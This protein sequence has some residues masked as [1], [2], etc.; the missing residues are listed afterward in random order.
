CREG[1]LL[2]DLPADQVRLDHAFDV[3]WVE[4]FVPSAFRINQAD[5][6]VLAHAQTAGFR[7]V[8][9]AV[10]EAELFEAALGIA[11]RL[12]ALLPRAA[13][14]AGAQEEVALIAADVEL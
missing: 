2:D 3:L 9:F 11:P 1:Q 6:A 5:R 4:P 7:A 13:L 14:L 8:D 10:G 12:F